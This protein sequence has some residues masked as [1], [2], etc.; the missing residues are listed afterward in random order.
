[1]KYQK[2][3]AQL[4]ATI[5]AAIVAATSDGSGITSVEWINVIILLLGSAAVVGAGEFPAGVWANVKFYLSAATAGFVTLLTFV[6][7]GGFAGMTLSNW[8]QVVLAV[9]AAL[10]IAAVNGPTVVES[11]NRPAAG[12]PGYDPATDTTLR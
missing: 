11:T 2:F 4:V 8:I 7:V 3:I 5:L 10:G 9:G 6:S 1:M 12:G